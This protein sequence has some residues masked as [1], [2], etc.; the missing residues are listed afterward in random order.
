MRFPQ[1][2]TGLSIAAASLLAQPAAAQFFWAPPD[3]TAPSMNDAAAAQA[4]GLPGATP[5][6]I[7]AGL[8]WNL[9]AALNVAAL[10]CQFEPT[11]LAISNYNATIAH[12]DAE[13]DKAQAG[14][15]GYFQ[16]TVGKGKPG[17]NA[18]DMYGTRIYSGY[19]TVQA[20]KGFCLAA[21]EVGRKAIFAE[22]GTLNQVARE[23][24]ASIKKALVLQGE[25][26][27]GTPGYDYEVKHPSFAA[28]CWKKE[29]L[30]PT[31]QQEWNMAAGI[32]TPVDPKAAKKKKKG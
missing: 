19:S 12:H 29:V 5:D 4:L 11:L 17:Q 15:L 26:F 6:E 8:V 13:M 25:Q 16:R 21:A 32:E 30:Q 28:A 2:L 23:G 14:V 1:V 3:L 10:Q 18:A 27:Y 31:C 24:L 9:R 7:N 20:Q 22:R